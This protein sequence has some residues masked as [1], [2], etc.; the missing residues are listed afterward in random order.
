MI[1][2]CAFH[3][4]AVFGAS[5]LGEGSDEYRTG[6][7]L[8]AF[9]ATRGAAVRCGGYY[10]LMEAVA[11]GVRSV[12]GATCIGVT[13]STFDPKIANAYLSEEVKAGDPFERLRLL[14]NGVSLVVV[15]PGSFGTL[16]ELFVTLFLLY[17]GCISLVP[18]CLLGRRWRQFVEGLSSLPVKPEHLELF[19]VFDSA[20]AFF[21][22][23]DAQM[24]TR[25]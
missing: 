4:V 9:L 22:W 15:Q 8:G 25:L 2:G 12:E 3:S 18:V 21:A 11:R 1:Q 20:D 14:I 19:Q 10:G 16:A 7:D 6:V 24:P 23:F 17:T 5:E 13:L